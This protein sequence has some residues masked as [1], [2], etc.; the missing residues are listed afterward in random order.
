M[1]INHRYTV[2]RDYREHKYNLMHKEVI[3]VT[4][5]K[6]VQCMNKHIGDVTY[7]VSGTQ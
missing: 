1:S 3:I 6:Q 5:I 4:A 7:N 2:N